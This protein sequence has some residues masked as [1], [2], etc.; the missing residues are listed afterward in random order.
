MRFDFGIWALALMPT[1]ALAVASPDFARDVRPVFER[2]CYGCHGPEKQKN[3]YR[4]DVRDIA[5]KGGDSGEA[6]VVP[7]DAKRS[8]LI[9]YVSGEDE[10]MLMPPKQSD[11]PRLTAAE[12]ETLRAWIDAGPAWP[13]E[14]AGATK[15]PK[16][17]WSL[18]P[19]LKPALASAGGNPIDEFIGAKL[20]EK[21]LAIS[22][23]AD[24]RTQI[25]RLS[26]DLTGLPP[27][28]EEVEAFV[29][30]KDVQ[31]HEKLVTRLLASPRYGEQ[32]A[33]HWLDVAHYADTHGND[34]DHAR[35]NAWPYRDYVI[36]AFNEDKPYARFVQEQVAG[37]ALFPADPQA[38]IALG[39]L[40]AGP[41]DE[42]LMVGVREDT[43]D[44]RLAQVLDRDDMVT[45]VM[46]TFQSLTV[47]CARCHNHKFD[48]VSQRDYYALQA[49]FAGVDRADRPYDAEVATHARRQ[50]LL[51]RKAA[52]ARRDA[53]LLTSLD[54]PEMQQK[55]AAIADRHARRSE[56]WQPLDVVSVTSATG[57]DTSFARQT[58][59]SWFV[60]GAR[61]DK[62]TFIVTAQTKAKDIRAL[63]LEALPDERLP[64]KGPGRYDP[65]GNFHLTEFRVHAQPGSGETMGAVRVEFARATADHSDQGDVIENAID[66]RADTHWS[67]HPRYGEAHEA[68]FEFKAPLSHDAGTTF[69]VR[70]EHNGTA[71]HQ[72]GRFRLSFS[73]GALPADQHEPLS[74]VVTDLLRKPEAQRTPEERRELSLQV[75]S[76][77]VERSLAALPVPQMVYAATRDFPANGSH[78]PAPFPR[79]IHLLTRGD[80]NKPAE[81][82][83]PAALA[84]L[85]GLEAALPIA[86]LNEESARRAALARWLTD[87]RNALLWRSIVNRVWHYHFG[88]GLCDTPND[89]GKMGG[90][91]SHPELLDWL[92]VWF[93]DEAHGSLKA[94][95]RLIVTSATY[96]QAVTQ[97]E[98]AMALDADNRLLWRMNRSR[99]TA[100]QVRDSLLH[101]SGQLD[102]TMGGPAA[103]Q[104]VHRG[105]A[106]FMPDGGAPA[107]LDYE[108]FPPDSPEN[109]RRAIYRFVFRTVADPLMDA[110][111]APDGGALTPVRSQSTTALQAFALLNN[112]FVI[113]Q[114]EHIAARMEK[115]APAN[116]AIARTFRLLLQRE[117]N[118]DELTRF[119]AYAQTH[120]LANAVHVIINSNEFLHLD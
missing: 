4:L 27:T 114:C 16:P 78:K 52:I 33:R 10:E 39:F 99:L 6:A 106:T 119:T 32:W 104:F 20:A 48:P 24:A 93:R 76:A 62:D 120:G 50:D 21:G 42:T 95:H 115:D 46:S 17:H 28:P 63:R 11:K 18:T 22:P 82:I 54:A 49:V 26:Y 51:A 14:L 105:K 12:V 31:A 1:V 41:W 66:G 85:P 107:F 53:A 79:P 117:A 3:G 112:A 102:L 37:D 80:P 60:S 74:A 68:V 77:E 57:A 103:V 116:A 87:D 111:D 38:T 45:T 73:T 55:V 92:A 40:A 29:A 65:A 15:D 64:G 19:L 7:H 5:I 71:A 89:F 61:P 8:P 34:H 13:D 2:S 83:G 59:G 43:F 9:R 35:P 70:L 90:T 94:L 91:P 23:K 98:D 97:R 58:D 44:H 81:L 56:A 96:R 118:A 67:I 109:R 72:L 100:E 75:L 101:M 86:D 30:D 88:R 69:I 47:H 110:L 108:A 84:C 36:R 113:R 25:R